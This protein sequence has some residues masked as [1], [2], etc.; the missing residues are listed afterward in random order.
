M[1][2]F[3]ASRRDALTGQRRRIGFA[4]P[5]ALTGG[6]HVHRSR[7]VRNVAVGPPRYRQTSLVEAL[8]FQAGRRPVGSTRG[9]R[10][11]PTGGRSSAPADVALA[12]LSEDLEGKP[13]INLIDTRATSGFQADTVA[14]FAGR[15]KVRWS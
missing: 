13:E 5:V 10:R 15:R 4:R 1:V 11:G 12:A 2:L 14:A 6:Q 8:L 7:E 3:A 9:A